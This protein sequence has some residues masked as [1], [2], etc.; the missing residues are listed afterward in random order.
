MD[1][2]ARYE[3]LGAR[4]TDISRQIVSGGDK[5][6]EIYN[7]LASTLQEYK[8]LSDA[9]GDVDNEDREYMTMICNFLEKERHKAPRPN[10]ILMGRQPLKAFGIKR[11]QNRTT[12]PF[13]WAAD[14]LIRHYVGGD[15]T[16]CKKRP[17]PT[18]PVKRPYKKAIGAVSTARKRVNAAKQ[19]LADARDE[20]RVAAEATLSRAVERLDR[21]TNDLSKIPNPK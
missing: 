15:K 9:R 13:N 5:T 6:D 8:A 14:V 12:R 4:L 7:Q 20:R 19:A 18:K 1:A 11:R 10:P 2:N 21:A 16:P 3:E 17:V